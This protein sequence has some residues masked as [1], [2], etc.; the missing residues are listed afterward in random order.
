M[1][2]RLNGILLV[3]KPK[4]FTSHDVVAKLRRL[5]GERRIGHSGT[6]DP[7]ATG[8]LIVFIGRATRAVEFAEA[9]DKDYSAV[10]RPGIT[11]DTQDITG[12][13][14]STRENDV[15]LEG[16]RG[17]LPRFYGEQMQIPPMYSAIKQ[18]GRKL[19]DLARRGAEVE[20]KP[21]QII[22]SRLEA[23]GE[24]HG[25]FLLHVTCSKGT[26]IRTLCS[27][28]GEALGCGACL[29][30]L[31]RTRA[32]KFSVADAHTL[33]EIEQIGTEAFLRPV[34]TLFDLF[35]PLIADSFAER[36][37]RVGADFSLNVPEGKYRIY[38]ENGEF[39]MLGRAASGSM[40]TIKS[41]FEV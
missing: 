2:E 5:T 21:R 19:C 17:I 39:L 13:V 25:D 33:D 28:I 3:D 12:T 11:T 26:Y 29:S 6:L 18:N 30:E 40:S 1:A 9:D 24:Y 7:M 41:F 10:L 22:I 36:Q 23:V 32:G 35:P 38:S 37:I 34:D 8:L 27:D 16:L 4:E 31:R 20:R 14:L 15:T